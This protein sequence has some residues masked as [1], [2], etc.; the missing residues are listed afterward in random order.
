[1][2]LSFVNSLNSFPPFLF[3]R[4]SVYHLEL[5]Q[6]EIST[7]IISSWHFANYSLV[8]RPCFI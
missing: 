8:L 6:A 3:I 2:L 1:M 4:L 7:A 5:R